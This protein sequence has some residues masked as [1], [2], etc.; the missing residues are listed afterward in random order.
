MRSRNLLAKRP[1]LEWLVLHGSMGDVSTL[2]PTAAVG[3]AGSP[4]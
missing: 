1:M 3:N 4:V 2:A